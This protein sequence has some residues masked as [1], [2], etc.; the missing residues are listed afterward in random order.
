MAQLALGGAAQSLVVGAGAMAQ[1]LVVGAG[2]MAQ[3]LAGAR[4]RVFLKLIFKMK[5]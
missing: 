2:A 1:S 4:A 3:S 5:R